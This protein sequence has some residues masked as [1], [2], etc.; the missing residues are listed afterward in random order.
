MTSTNNSENR[1]PHHSH[2]TH[3]NKYEKNHK[4]FNT[5]NKS[6]NDMHKGQKAKR[7]CTSFT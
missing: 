4:G 6:F 5:G 2:R 1:K 7:P 3:N